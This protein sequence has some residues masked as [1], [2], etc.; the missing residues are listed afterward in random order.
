MEG[1]SIIIPIAGE[2]NLEKLLNSINYDLYELIIVGNNIDKSILTRYRI[3]FIKIDVNRSEA[4]NIGAINARNEYLLFLDS[5]MELTNNFIE[6]AI[7]NIK[8]FDALIFPEI[9]VGNSIIAKGRRFER[10]GLYKTLYYEAPRMIKKDVFINLGGYNEELNA[11]ED[12]DLTRKLLN[13]NFKMGWSDNIIIHHEEDVNLFNY[14]RKRIN[15]T[16]NNKKIFLNNDAIFFK[17]VIKLKNRYNAFINSI[18]IYKL[19]SIYYLPSY[20]MVT[21]INVFTFMI[22]K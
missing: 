11:F 5:D 10:A 1:V 13:D 6:S 9:T 21:L 3:N 18:R 22:I 12:L 20:L 15:Y 19:K 16:K 8:N 4:R 17:Q 14:I 2:T 7:N